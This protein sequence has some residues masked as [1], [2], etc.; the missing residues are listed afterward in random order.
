MLVNAAE[1][2]TQ[3][4]KLI[5]NSVR[6]LS[7]NMDNITLDNGPYQDL[8]GMRKSYGK[9]LDA[10]FEHSI[11]AFE[12]IAEFT[13]W[14]NYAEKN[15]K[16][17]YEEINA[18]A[19]ATATKDG[20]PSCRMVLLKGYGKDGF[21]FYT[22]YASRKGQ[23]LDQNPWASLMFYWPSINRSIRIEGF[24]SKMPI[25]S[26]EEYWTKR[27]IL[28]QASAFVSQQSR[29]VATR[30][31]LEDRIKEVKTKFMDESK[32]IPRPENWGGYVLV[33]NQFEF[34]HGSEDR[35]HDRILFRK[36]KPNEIV[37]DKCLRKGE[38]DWFY[39]RLQ[40]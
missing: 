6:R 30:Q 14:F 21:R 27:P 7:K 28:S 37:D 32:L 10:Y 17:G 29:P 8:H 13:S 16:L 22:N 24:V 12:P 1:V 38:D 40:P 11:S 2:A 35:L 39:E 25:A 26:A 15:C 20:K 31:E 34:W 18:M 36:L 3:N 9:D 5:I 19:L 33:P 23:E 4:F